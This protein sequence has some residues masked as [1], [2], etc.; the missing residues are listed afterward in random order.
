MFTLKM[1]EQ[2]LDK[3]E[4]ES[5]KGNRLSYFILMLSFCLVSGGL[6]FKILHWPFAFILIVSGATIYTALS[7]WYL[8]RSNFK[9]TMQYGRV[10]FA[11]MMLI[12]IKRILHESY[13]FLAVMVFSALFLAL[14]AWLIGKTK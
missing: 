12:T 2:I 14:L 9:G 4:G 10:L 6:L 5:K 7:I 1:E 8:I 13:L 11:I 3:P